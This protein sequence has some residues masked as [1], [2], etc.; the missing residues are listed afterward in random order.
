MGWDEWSQRTR[1]CAVAGD[2]ATYQRTERGHT[3]TIT[4]EPTVTDWTDGIDTPLAKAYA[5]IFAHPTTMRRA[6]EAGEALAAALPAVNRA[7]DVL[8][9]L[10]DE[11]QGA[12]L[13][14]HG[15]GI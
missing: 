6:Q 10:Q 14:L 1:Q 13:A 5:E 7:M 4:T 11:M 15:I 8:V 12:V 2:Y 3:M 9:S